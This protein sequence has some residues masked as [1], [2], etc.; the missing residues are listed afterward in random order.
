MKNYLTQNI[1]S[2]EAEPFRKVSDTGPSFPRCGIQAHLFVGSLSTQ[3]KATVYWMLN[4]Y[5]LSHDIDKC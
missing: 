4:K 1:N 3:Q 2:A 5:Q